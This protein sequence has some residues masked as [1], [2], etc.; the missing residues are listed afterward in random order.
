[1]KY[2]YTHILGAIYVRSSVELLKVTCHVFS[3][4]YSD[5]YPTVTYAHTSCL[6]VDIQYNKYISYS[7][8]LQYY[9]PLRLSDFISLIIKMI[10]QNESVEDFNNCLAKNMSN[11]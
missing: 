4:I 2:R 1:M 11:C 8:Q 10:F 7:G 3:F 9:S 5:M 6:L